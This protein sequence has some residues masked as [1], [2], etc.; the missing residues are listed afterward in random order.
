MPPQSPIE[1]K[2]IPTQYAFLVH[3]DGTMQIHQVTTPAKEMKFDTP[4]QAREYIKN[5][6]EIL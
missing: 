4:K 1:Y 5:L 3:E 6:E 2:T